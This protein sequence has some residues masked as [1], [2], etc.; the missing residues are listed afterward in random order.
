M[1][2]GTRPRVPGV[3][4]RASRVASMETTAGVTCSAM[5]T[6]ALLWSASGLISCD[7]GRPGFCA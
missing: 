7:V 1:P 6:N 2:G 3:L 5:A 4:E